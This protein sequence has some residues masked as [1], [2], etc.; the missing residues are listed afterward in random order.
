MPRTAKYRPPRAKPRPI[1]PKSIE[2][3]PSAPKA[4]DPPS[5]ER[6]ERLQKV[7]AAAGV[8]SRR[9]CE[10]LITSDRVEVDRQVVNR[11]GTRVDPARQEIRVDGTRLRPSRLVYFLL[12]KPR[13]VVSTNLDPTGRP[14]VIDM[15]PAGKER[16]FPVG[17]LDISSEGLILVTNDGDLANRLTHPRYGVEKTY[18]VEVAGQLDRDGL[19]ALRKGAYLAEGFAR[20]T[21]AKIRDVRKQSTVLE[22][23]LAEGRNREIRRLLARLG[24]KV[25]RLKRIAIGP[26][27]LGELAPGESRPL[28]RDE[29]RKL[30]DDSSPQARRRRASER[31]ERTLARRAHTAGK[32]TAVSASTSEAAAPQPTPPRPAPRRPT[33]RK[34]NSA[35]GDILGTIIGAGP[36]LREQRGPKRK[37]PS[38]AGRS[39]GKRLATS[40]DRKPRRPKKQR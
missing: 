5:D 34:R 37:P 40:A 14:R 3:T 32:A 21:L 33:L 15:L 18:V 4:L 39:T 22:I 35:T 29:V 36:P 11:L 30:R 6:G 17:R 8:G 12:N 24:H 19:I 1:A 9:H 23:V 7:L 38:G 25:M 10:E 31:R 26:V 13:G 28:S 27:R 20:P 16:L 2:P